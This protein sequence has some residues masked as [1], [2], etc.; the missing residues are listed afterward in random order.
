MAGYMFVAYLA[1]SDNWVLPTFIAVLGVACL[2]G[3]VKERWRRQKDGYFIHKRGGAKDGI[4]IY[5]EKGN[6]LQL[7]FNRQ[8]DTIYVPSDMEW[9][10]VMP[11]WA[12]DRKK[13][14]V[15]RIKARIGKRLVGKDWIYKETDR[16][17]FVLRNG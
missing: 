11:H 5:N 14:I 8:K 13:E 2:Y 4:L 9:S 1:K 16:P 15:A 17:E 3:I 10:K 6:T 7:Y 12:K